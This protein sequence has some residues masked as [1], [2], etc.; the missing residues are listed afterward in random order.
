MSEIVANAVDVQSVIAG[1][2]RATTE[3]TR[4]IQEVNLAVMQLDGMVQQNAALV[5]QSA[6]AATF[7]QAQASSLA[8]A[9]EQFKVE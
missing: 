1:I 5:E 9:I 8:F 7:L 6:A 4:G 3:Q 2:A